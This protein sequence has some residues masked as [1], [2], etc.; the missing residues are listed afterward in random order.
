[1]SSNHNKIIINHC[2]DCADYNYQL[3]KRGTWI[4]PLDNDFS[5]IKYVIC[6]DDLKTNEEINNIYEQNS[7]QNSRNAGN[8]TETRKIVINKN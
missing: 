7:D 4:E 3:I 2:S 8:I 6:A 5:I 1:M